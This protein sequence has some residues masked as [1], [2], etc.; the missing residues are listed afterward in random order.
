MN[1]SESRSIQKQ[2]KE[3]Y[4]TNFPSGG[5]LI[6]GVSGGPDSMA[7][8]Y[9]LHKNEIPIFAVHINYGL[10][11]DD[12]DADKQLVEEVCAMWDIECCSVNLDSSEVS[13]NFQN[14]ARNQRYQIFRDLKTEIRASGIATAHHADD[15]IET[16]LFKILR[17]GGVTSWKGTN[18]WDEEIFR[19]LLHL[20]K[21]EIIEFCKIESVPF[22][23][24]ES[25]DANTYA[26]NA[27]RNT[28]FPVFDE[29]IPGWQ[30]NLKT[31]GNKAGVTDEA[32]SVLLENLSE[33][34]SL[35]VS[36]MNHFSNEL[37]GSLIKRFLFE[38]T[39]IKLS[40][41]QLLE[42][43]ALLGSQTG[44]VLLLTEKISLI[45]GRGTLT[46]KRNGSTGIV[47][48]SISE[49]D[50]ENEVLIGDWKLKNESNKSGSDLRISI[51]EIIW[52]IR[53]R[54]WKS[55]DQIQPFGM[56]GTQNLS[57]HLTNRKINASQREETL[58]LI[59]SG[60][61]ICAILYP[62]VATNDENG[63]IS[64]LVKIT[65]ST[66]TVLSISKT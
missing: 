6:L 10:R 18:V 31:V 34:D 48:I 40:K 21:K 51:D 4:K 44:K 57:D 39:G 41:G 19:P 9:L 12:S 60:G 23:N 32:L 7:L 49:K 14:W 2:I 11:G 33:N 66:K 50:L 28:V 36:D 3:S 47:D 25:N 24:D 30:S 55:G 62:E 63:C 17:G 37:I 46:I 20:S 15:Q 27:L 43:L 38:N 56:S 45:K 26:R 16:I 8:L 5:T 54:N 64:E 42:A 22:R 65:Q 58:I 29:F 53:I 52:P 1:K 13:G 59:D 35:L 61:T